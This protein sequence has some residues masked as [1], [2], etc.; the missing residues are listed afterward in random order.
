MNGL[1]GYEDEQAHYDTAQVCR[2]GHVINGSFHSSPEFNQNFCDKC[3]DATVI[4]CSSCAAEIRGDYKSPDAMV[5]TGHRPPAPNYCHNCGQPYPWTQ[6]RLTLARE[7]AD[8]FDE[9]DSSDKEK[10]KGTLDDLVKDSPKTDLATGR[11]KK[12]MAKVGKDS[13]DA[14]RRII[15]DI[16]SETAKKT[17]FPKQ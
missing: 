7:L 4:A 15:T 13:Y 9:L 6:K 3:G 17:L 1:F 5:I 2:N 12:I 8:E 10:L 14:M 16:I 11:F